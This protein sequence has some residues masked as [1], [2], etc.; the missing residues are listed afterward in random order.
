MA[1]KPGRVEAIWDLRGERCD[2]S[3]GVRR[4]LESVALLELERRD[5]AERFVQAVV[6]EPCHVRDD[7]EL[8]LA[9]RPP[10]AIANELGLEA[11]DEA[12]GERVVVGVADRAD[13]CEDVVVVEDLAKVDARVLIC[14][15][16]NGARDR[17]RRREPG[18]PAPSA[19]R[20]APGRCACGW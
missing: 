17:R 13:R 16:R 18:W 1:L 8:E 10:H 12:L 19:A 11:V 6:V 3:V 9:A 4:G 14:R 2:R 7:G 15:R 5:V 20:R